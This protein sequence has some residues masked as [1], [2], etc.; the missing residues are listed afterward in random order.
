MGEERQTHTTAVALGTKVKKITALPEITASEKSPN[1]SLQPRQRQLCKPL[2][3][4][5]PSLPL[6][7]HRVDAFPA[8]S[9]SL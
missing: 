9:S 5:L 1:L 6:G 8:S 3:D 4:K 2:Q 7:T